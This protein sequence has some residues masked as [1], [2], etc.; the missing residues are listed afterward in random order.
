MKSKVYDAINDIIKNLGNE[1]STMNEMENLINKY[2]DNLMRD[3]RNDFPNL[4]EDEY[5]LF[6][7]LVVGFSS[8]AIAV[9]LQVK[10]DVVYNR[11]SSLKR[12]IKLNEECKQDNYTKYF[13]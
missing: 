12:K 8:R 10:T 6:I 3:F 9:L 7:Y 13:L 1:P 2:Y 11:K 4:R 5:K